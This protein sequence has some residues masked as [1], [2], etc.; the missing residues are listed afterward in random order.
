MLL[1]FLQF[2]NN[3]LASVNT[4][5]SSVYKLKSQ[6]IMT[7]YQ[8]SV[9]PTMTCKTVAIR[10]GVDATSSW[11][12]A[13]DRFYQMFKQWSNKSE[14]LRFGCIWTL[15]CRSMTLQM[16]SIRLRSAEL[17]GQDIRLNQHRVRETAPKQ[18][19][20][21]DTELCPLGTINIQ[22]ERQ[23]PCTG[24]MMCND[25]PVMMF[26]YYKCEKE[27]FLSEM[28]EINSIWVFFNL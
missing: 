25:E 15:N 2:I 1:Q 12:M 22:L 5:R 11:Q 13:R 19:E 7:T 9:C 10:L 6:K 17:G 14:I 21:C 20:S 4:V 8:W 26:R 24:V 18:F 23:L 28:S 3:F 16:C 27:R